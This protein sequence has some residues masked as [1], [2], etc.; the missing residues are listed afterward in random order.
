MTKKPL[1][2]KP[3]DYHADIINIVEPII[4][5]DNPTKQEEYLKRIIE[6]LVIGNAP[7]CG[8]TISQYY[9]PECKTKLER[10][11]ETVFWCPNCKLKVGAML[12]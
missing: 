4:D 7:R 12:R 11:G 1:G 6:A 9:C 5:L 3:L 8:K 10:I 2:L